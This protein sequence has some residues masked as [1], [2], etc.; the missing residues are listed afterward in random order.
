MVT[1]LLSGVCYDWRAQ[2]TLDTSDDAIEG[3]A[4]RDGHLAVTATSLTFTGDQDT[5]LQLPLTVEFAALERIGD[6]VFIVAGNGNQLC[7]VVVNSELEFTFIPIRCESSSLHAVA[8]HSSDL[9]VVGCRDRVDAYFFEPPEF[10]KFASLECAER[11]VMTFLPHPMVLLA[12]AA[13]TLLQFFIVTPAGLVP[14]GDFSIAKSP[15]IVSSY[16]VMRLRA[17]QHTDSGDLLG[18]SDRL[19]FRVGLPSSIFPMPIPPCSE[20]VL[21]TALTVGHFGVL[22]AFFSGQ[23]VTQESFHSHVTADEFHFSRQFLS[24]EGSIGEFL[25]SSED[26]RHSRIVCDHRETRDSP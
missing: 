10:V 14:T 21:Y 2:A 1:R 16:P 3:L 12:V 9:F 17:L 13:G 8:I 19:F 24:S 25:T 11:P 26:F 23:P 22:T 5:E 4:F 15:D 6:R 20:Y 18:A 7:A